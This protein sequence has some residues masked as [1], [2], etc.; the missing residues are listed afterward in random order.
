MIRT[1]HASSIATITIARPARRNALTPEA[2]VQLRDALVAADDDETISVIIIT[3]EGSEAFCAGADI[4]ATL[5]S[6]RSFISAYFD[7]RSDATHPLYI[8]NIAFGRMALRKPTIAAV[9]GV[10][11]GGG[12]EIALN[13]DMCLA[14]TNARFG[15]TE[16]RIGSIPAVSGIQRLLRSLPRPVAMRLLLSGEIVDA[17]F[18]LQW[19]LV[20]EVVPADALLTRANELASMIAANAPLAVRT[21]KMLADKAEQLSLTEATEVE[22]LMWGHLYGTRD[23]IEGRKAF[24]EKR[25]PRF[26][27]E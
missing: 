23:R 14:A 6:E 1:E 16:V 17:S 13:C 19:G 21:A 27:G 22:E 2:M 15:L 8:R 18:A 7:R 11:V 12:M 3:G 10:A 25:A 5:P 20:S 9:N 4:G 26:R 24:S